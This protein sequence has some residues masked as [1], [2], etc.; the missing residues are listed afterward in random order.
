MVSS[1][2]SRLWHENSTEQRGF[3]E[4]SHW[5]DEDTVGRVPGRAYECLQGF[6]IDGN[7]GARR[8][9]ELVLRGGSP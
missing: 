6:T 3:P 1:A 7:G 8:G 4:H 2:L 5:K 9:A